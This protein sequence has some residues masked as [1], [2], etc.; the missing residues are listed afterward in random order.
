MRTKILVLFAIALGLSAN[1]LAQVTIGGMESP[2]AGALLDLNSTNKGGLLLSNVNLN[3]LY[4]IPAEIS[5]SSSV[6]L[7]E[8]K[9]A[10]VYNTNPANGIGVYVWNGANWTPADR[11][12]RE[13]TTVTLNAPDRVV[14]EN[15]GITI[16][17]LT[18][19][20]PQCA[21]D[22]TYEWYMAGETDNYGSPLAE[23]GP[24]LTLTSTDF[25]PQSLAVYKVKVRVTN[26][27]SPN[28]RESEI[29]VAV[30][31]CPAKINNTEWLFFMCNNL[32]GEPVTSVELAST[33]ITRAHHGDWYKFGEKYPALTNGQYETGPVPEWDYDTDPDKVNA[34]TYPYFE[35][36]GD[37]GWLWPAD[38]NPCP[39]GWRV[40]SDA[41]WG[42]VIMYTN[43]GASDVIYYP[44]PF[45]NANS[46]F[47]SVLQ[48][49]DYL[50]LP[51]AGMRNNSDGSL[52]NRGLSGYYCE[53]S[54]YNTGKVLFTSFNNSG[55]SHSYTGD[56]QCARSVRC[57]KE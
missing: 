16:S 23:T 3:K 26:P 51:A 35:G 56:P 41:Q 48:I 19:A 4:E 29:G 1:L 34:T 42:A 32:G 49:G 57:I 37:A 40:P 30:G 24:S 10:M 6:D 18:D 39:A 33:G 52:V 45:P 53:N 15:K 46:V 21:K 2:K 25:P 44:N 43:Y 11:D 54:Y 47:S 9:G 22:E 55:I 5:G 27:Y 13:L 7:S 17:V 12:C 38:K 28:F 31:G 50:F 14:L 36:S 8:F 20:S